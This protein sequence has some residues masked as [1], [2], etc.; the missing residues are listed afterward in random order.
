MW[1]NCGVAKEHPELFIAKKLNDNADSVWHNRLKLG[2]QGPDERDS[3]HVDE[4]AHLLKADLHLAARHDRSDRF[5]GRRTANLPTLA[6]DLV[7][8]TELGEQRGQTPHAVE[9]RAI[10]EV[11]QSGD[12]GLCGLG[13]LFDPIQRG[14]NRREHL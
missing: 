13:G 7:R 5:A 2:G 12:I 10:A 4:L 3:R 8:D 6:R 11:A 14:E 1:K 9:E